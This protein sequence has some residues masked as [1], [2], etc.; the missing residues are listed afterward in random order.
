[1]SE[2]RKTNKFEID[3]EKIKISEEELNRR[4]AATII[5]NQ[6]ALNANEALKNTEFYEKEIKLKINALLPVLIKKEKEHFDKIYKA[7][8]NLVYAMSTEVEDVVNTLMKKNLV[9]V[10]LVGKMIKALE[11]NEKAVLGIVNKVLS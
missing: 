10:L 1:M 9:T 8:E 11:V 7:N 6:M 5:F 3:L 4:L 2:L